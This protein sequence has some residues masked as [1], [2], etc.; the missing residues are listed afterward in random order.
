MAIA[1]LE[2][3]AFEKLRLEVSVTMSLTFLSLIHTSG[4]V[5]EHV[6]ELRQNAQ[7]IDELDVAISF[8]VLAE[9]M[10]FVRPEIVDE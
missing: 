4:K 5:I 10:K 2:K 8:S 3:D 1:L 7:V 6:H 9:E